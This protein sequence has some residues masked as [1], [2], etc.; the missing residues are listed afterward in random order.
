MSKSIA[1]QTAKA[2]GAVSRTSARTP[3]PTKRDAPDSFVRSGQL[4]F[5]RR[6]AVARRGLDQTVQRGPVLAF[7]GQPHCQTSL[8]TATGGIGHPS[9]AA[10]I[11]KS[12]PSSEVTWPSAAMQ[13]ET[14]AMI[15][16]FTFGL[17]WARA[18]KAASKVRCVHCCRDTSSAGRRRY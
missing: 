11:R 18:A 15:L 16:R 5:E 13:A 6:V 9:T 8:A 7:D 3:T 17:A 1:R 14:A 2:S 4:G 10:T 12:S